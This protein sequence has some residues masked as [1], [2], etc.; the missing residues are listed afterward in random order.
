MLERPLSY[1]LRKIHVKEEQQKSIKVKSHTKLQDKGMRN[2][3][4]SL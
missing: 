2:R 1:K 3:I 4:T